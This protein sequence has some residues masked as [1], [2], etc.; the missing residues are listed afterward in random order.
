M[1]ILHVQYY[2]RNT[3]SSPAL[4]ILSIVLLAASPIAPYLGHMASSTL[5]VK[6]SGIPGILAA[7][8]LT[9]QGKYINIS[10]FLITLLVV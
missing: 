1:L 8:C 4:V 5:G 6:F 9:L 3:D 10:I 2:F 7:I